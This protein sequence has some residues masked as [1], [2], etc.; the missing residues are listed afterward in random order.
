[1]VVFL[2]RN[3]GVPAVA[4]AGV[5]MQV[6]LRPGAHT[7]EHV[8]DDATARLG[9]HTAA[10]GLCRPDGS[11]IAGL[12]DLTPKCDL[13]VLEGRKGFIAP[14][15]EPRR[16][17]TKSPGRSTSP[18]RTKAPSRTSS[19]RPPS[20]PRQRH[21]T[22]PRSAGR[23]SIPAQLSGGSQSTGAESLLSVVDKPLRADARTQD[24][25]DSETAA[26]RGAGGASSQESAQ[27]ET[28]RAAAQ[29]D[30]RRADTTEHRVSQETPARSRVVRVTPRNP[31][32]EVA[33]QR[34]GQRSSRKT[35]LGAQL[36]ENRRKHAA[37]KQAKL[38]RELAATREELIT[39][40]DNGSES[41]DVSALETRSWGNL[42][43]TWTPPP[44]E[45]VSSID[46]SVA[47]EFGLTDASSIE[48]ASTP[49]EAAQTRLKT[50]PQPDATQ[51]QK[52]DLEPEPEPEPEPGP[53]PGP[54]LETVSQWAASLQDSQPSAA[55]AL[56]DTYADLYVQVRAIYN[57]AHSTLQRQLATTVGGARDPLL[58]RMADLVVSMDALA[59]D[60]GAM[61]A[62][63]TVGSM[64]QVSQL[65]E[66]PADRDIVGGPSSADAVIDSGY[67]LAT[68]DS[69]Q[70]RQRREPPALPSTATSA[71]DNYDTPTQAEASPVSESGKVIDENTAAVSIQAR[72]RGRQDRRRATVQKLVA[73]R[74]TRDDMPVVGSRACCLD[75]PIDE[76]LAAQNESTL[77]VKLQEEFGVQ[78]LWDLVAVIQDPWDWTVVLDE[79]DP[80][81]S[82]K[83]WKSMQHLIAQASDETAGWLGSHSL[84]NH[85]QILPRAAPTSD[86][87]DGNRDSNGIRIHAV[88]PGDDGDSTG[89]VLSLTSTSSVDNVASTPRLPPPL[90]QTYSSTEEGKDD[91]DSFEMRPSA[92]RSS[93]SK[94]SGPFTPTSFRA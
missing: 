59:A 77:S 92:S 80:G 37:S 61:P 87:A 27:M 22:P 54:E 81:R 28:G 26:V 10:T 64:V 72:V 84:K 68:A 50:I 29:P 52:P 79:P 86:H 9:L 60:I 94:G 49:S 75:L 91:A 51:E 36:L 45:R 3:D 16:K 2:H 71:A 12:D 48:E 57:T 6:L 93:A 73:L 66:T 78:S 83:L 47:I 19:E 42:A 70:P 43:E 76:W 23:A 46:N 5:R 14:G 8:L 62:G 24:E 40:C 11:T 31:A 58:V 17:R 55:D 33:L 39:G 41:S 18:S 74:E 82:D 20:L 34:R 1:M 63:A 56:G 30:T 65:S 25:L 88:S 35:K 85:K 4:G 69:G 32:R 13:V 38:K 67:A 7:L 15:G 44:L 53:E 90:P 21:R 89:L